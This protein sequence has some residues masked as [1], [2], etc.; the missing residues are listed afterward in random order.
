MKC[1]NCSKKMIILG[2]EWGRQ[3]ML[4][5]DVILLY[6]CEESIVNKMED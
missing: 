3:P 4:G 1:P 5:S 6:G 2:T